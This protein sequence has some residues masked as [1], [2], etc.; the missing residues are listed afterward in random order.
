MGKVK[1]HN[2]P[3]KPFEFENDDLVIDNIN[4]MK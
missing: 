3:P 1:I 2:G 4:G